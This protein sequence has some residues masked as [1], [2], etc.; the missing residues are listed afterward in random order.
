MSGDN[1]VV[2]V[3]FV[4]ELLILSCVFFFSYNGKETFS[5]DLDNG[6]EIVKKLS[7]VV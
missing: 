5:M 6:F 7:F 2:Y 3:L 4:Y 1:A